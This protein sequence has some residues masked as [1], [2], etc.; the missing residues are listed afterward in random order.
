MDTTDKNQMP[1]TVKEQILLVRDTGETNMFDCNAVMRIANREGWYELVEYLSD[2]KNWKTY[3]R[4]ILTGDTKPDDC[5]D[6][7]AA[8]CIP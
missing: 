4:L 6:G 5:K 7:G 3:S 1:Q 8:T 2:H